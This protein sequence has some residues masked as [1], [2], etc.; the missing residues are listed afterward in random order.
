MKKALHGRGVHVWLMMMTERRRPF[1]QPPGAGA[2]MEEQ[3]PN[4]VV[5]AHLSKVGCRPR[6]KPRAP[7]S[8]H[9]CAARGW[10]A[11]VCAQGAA[12]V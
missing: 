4:P 9:T 11:A 8:F 2:Y 5:V 6:V 12:T 3:I 1:K 10:S 7:L